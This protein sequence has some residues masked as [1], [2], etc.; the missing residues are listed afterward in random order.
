MNIKNLILTISAAQLAN[1][2]IQKPNGEDLDTDLTN[3]SL[4]SAS[5]QNLSN[6]ITVTDSAFK[7]AD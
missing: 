4:V 3:A 6:S 1:S 5:M 7:T 2:A